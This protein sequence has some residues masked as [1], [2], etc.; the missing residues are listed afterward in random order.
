[1]IV[2]PQFPWLLKVTPL[3][4]PMGKSSV[5]PGVPRPGC[6]PSSPLLQ[7]GWPPRTVPLSGCTVSVLDPAEM[8]DS[9]HVWRLQR[10]QQSLYL[11]TPSVDLQKRWLEAL[12]AA[13]RGDPGLAAL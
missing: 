10:G 5:V 12:S 4:P 13:A 3:L 11:S 2:G 1:M 7:D 6:S 8:P 9:R